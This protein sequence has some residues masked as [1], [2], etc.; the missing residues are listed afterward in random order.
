MKFMKPTYLAL[1]VAAASS[2]AFAAAPGTPSIS[3]GNDKFALVEV[4]QAAQ[5][6]KT[7]ITY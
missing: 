5:R 3:S 7:A 6:G 2:S 1:F 4:D